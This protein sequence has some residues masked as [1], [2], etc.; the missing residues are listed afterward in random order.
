MWKTAKADVGQL[1]AVLDWPLSADTLLQ[2]LPLPAQHTLPSVL[3][4]LHLTPPAM[5]ETRQ[6][7]GLLHSRLTLLHAGLPFWQTSK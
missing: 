4:L 2:L 6:R 3:R 7:E 1:P 5:H